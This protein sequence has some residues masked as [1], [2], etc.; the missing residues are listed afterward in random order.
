MTNTSPTFLTSRDVRAIV[1]WAL[2][3]LA[4]LIIV[5]RY[6][7]VAFPSASIDFQITRDEAETAAAE[8][9]RLQGHDPLTYRAVTVF[10]YDD[11][12]KVYLERELG[13]E[14]AN[15]LM[16]SQVT[17]W[18][19]NTRFF[20]PLE[21]EEF[22]VALNPAGRPVGFVHEIE[23]Q[24]EGANLTIEQAQTIAE[25]F[26]AGAQSLALSDYRLVEDETRTLDHRT[27][28]T[29]TW[30]RLRFKAQDAT[31]RITIT[32]QGNRLGGYAEYLKV[33]EAW[34]RDYALLRSR[35]SL[36]QQVTEVV[37]F[38]VVI[39]L[40][41]VF[42][43]ELGRQRLT[44]RFGVL[45]GGALAVTSLALTLNMLP[46]EFMAYRTT[47]SL[48]S[49]YG[50]IVF[51]ALIGA[52][53]W[54]VFTSLI[55]TTGVS[56]YRTQY[57]EK[58]APE[59]LL[60]NRTFR[61]GEY[62][63][64]TV[65]GYLIPLVMLGYI[66]AFYLIGN[67]FGVWSPAAIDYTDMASTSFP[68]LYPL[69]IGL[70]ASIFEEFVFRLFAISF[71]LRYLKSTF[72][73][74]LIPA[75]I[76]GFLHSA[77][78]QQPFFI[79]GIE[80]TV[81]GVMLGYVFIRYGILST[82]I[83]HYAFDALLLSIF[84]FQS[85]R[86]YFQV[87]G[88]LVVGIMVLPLVPSV[89]ALIRRHL[90]D[91]P[92][93][94]NAAIERRLTDAAVPVP[95]SEPAVPAPETHGPVPA[96]SKIPMVSSLPLSPHARFGILGCA[97]ISVVLL[98]SAP[99]ERF[100]DFLD[101]RIDRSQA[102]ASA[103]AYLAQHGVEVDR[104]KRVATFS[105]ASGS[106]GQRWNI[107]YIRRTE[108]LSRLNEV[109]RTRLNPAAWNV[110]FFMPLQ[111]EEYHVFVG[112]DGTISG[113][114]HKIEE[115]APGDALSHDTA[116][117]L[118]L[119]TLQGQGYDLAVYRLAESNEE[120]RDARTDHV[121]VWEDS[122][123]TI[124]E[125]TFRIQA[126]VQG[127]EVIRVRPFFKPPEAWIREQEKTSFKDTILFVLTAFAF[128][129]VIV[130][131]MRIYVQQIRQRRVDWRTGLSVAAVVTVVSLL[132]Q[133]NTS[134]VIFASYR[135]TMSL[136][137]FVV[138]QLL[139]GFVV[140]AIGI[141]LVGTILFSFTASCY[142]LEYPDRVDLRTWFRETVRLHTPDARTA[143]RNALF[144]SYAACFLAPGLRHLMQM[145]EQA[146]DF[147]TGRIAPIVPYTTSYLPEISALLHAVTSTLMGS[148][149]LLAV[150]LVA[151]H[152][153]RRPIVTVSA[154]IL[155]IILRQ[156]GNADTWIEFSVRSME[157]ILIVGA[158]WFLF[159][160]LWRDNLLAY[161]LTFFLV[162]LT[163]DGWA[164][165]SGA[166]GAYRMAGIR[167]LMLAAL[168]L[169]LWGVLWIKRRKI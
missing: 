132:E 53:G 57:P 80:L 88:A 146:I 103:E 164:M 59:W 47:Q 12:A 150:V 141:M 72:L 73:A 131:A 55:G 67:R 44:W 83:A 142:P 34:Q 165:I 5:L 14:Q 161:V 4:G 23:E 33:P 119:N 106:G 129:G 155:L 116:L 65:I 121:F 24:R 108:G 40:L 105:R 127:D 126:T 68:W 90:A 157:Q 169:V 27:D 63:L 25:R 113:Y 29:F 66:T 133:V 74:V 115:T 118:A 107:P 100:L 30:E 110:R 51:S 99:I 42:V 128:G 69:S 79:R 153:V 151:R 97:A 89:I 166:S 137:S 144:L 38:G 49:F 135:T 120:Q 163:G 77:Y 28:H 60:T 71:L 112:T 10:D 139:M 134:G 102:T 19:W 46:L 41:V 81:V 162:S 152:Y 168:P 98:A 13:L 114:D 154:V 6:H 160:S 143:V 26:L 93:L 37:F 76:W 11:I 122:V 138:Q 7:A 15:T 156:S 22:T 117:A 32:I 20:R 8:F 50:F 96:V 86:L 9:L 123:T 17:V 125:G 95:A 130:L 61:T 36:A 56:V 78:P 3:A 167:I 149:L 58:L 109:Y 2:A 75:L 140:N 91:D 85:S 82:L 52:S 64:A 111:K 45:C 43:R 21:Q 148:A 94:S 54:F 124:G 31:A 70:Q 159:R 18:Q 92:A 39:A 87:A 104:F 84:L 1:L 62:F 101:M 158:V 145:V 48:A 16:Q 136:E 147:S 35:N